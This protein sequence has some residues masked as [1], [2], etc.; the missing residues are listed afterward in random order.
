MERQR[1]HLED[2]KSKSKTKREREII[3]IP[4]KQFVETLMNEV[5]EKELI[6]NGRLMERTNSRKT[7]VREVMRVQFERQY[8]TR[9]VVLK[10]PEIFVAKDSLP[11]A[12]FKQ[13][14]K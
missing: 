7:R 10:P 12:D 9:Q 6:S 1:R 8:G 14:A 5:A 4:K 2:E 3:H 11:E 13:M